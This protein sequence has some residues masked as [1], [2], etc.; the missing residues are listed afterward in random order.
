MII[1]HARDT[2]WRLRTA[3]ICLLLIAVALSL[4]LRSPSLVWIT[5]VPVMS[6]TL[7]TSVGWASVGV[8]GSPPRTLT[9]RARRRKRPGGPAATGPL[10]SA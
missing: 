7:Q 8:A 9:V 6:K 4:P 3:G 1:G 5:V 2:R 10:S